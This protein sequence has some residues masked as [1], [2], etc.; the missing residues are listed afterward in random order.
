MIYRFYCLLPGD[1]AGHLGDERGALYRNHRV[2]TVLL[3][4]VHP[5]STKEENALKNAST[6]SR[7]GV[8]GSAFYPSPCLLILPRPIK[9]LRINSIA[10]GVQAS[11]FFSGIGKNLAESTIITKYSFT[12]L[13]ASLFYLV[14]ILPLSRAILASESADRSPRPTS[15]G[16]DASLIPADACFGCIRWRPPWMWSPPP[17]GIKASVFYSFFLLNSTP[18]PVKS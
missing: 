2:H 8:Q 11:A 7:V 3:S 12:F 18:R 16:Q 14:M 5:G 1:A 13:M 15:L 4:F 10:F 17:S 9:S 6:F